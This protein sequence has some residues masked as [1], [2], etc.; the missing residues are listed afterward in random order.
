MTD[1]EN[2]PAVELEPFVER[3]GAGVAINPATGEALELEAATADRLFD[4]LAA[5]GDLQA[6]LGNHRRR[7][8][9]ELARR[10]DARNERTV[11]LDGCDYTVNAPTEDVI[12]VE[13]I[14]EQAAVFER[15]ADDAVVAGNQ[16]AAALYG[17]RAHLLRRLIVTPPP[18][19]PPARVDKRAYARLAKS[20]DRELLGALAAARRRV[21]TKRTVTLKARVLNTT[22]EE[23]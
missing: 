14:L 23:V 10:A 9:L 20:D 11:T 7:V 12:D 8:E 4:E 18:A 21:P 5:V 19:R 2:T 16:E 22:A 15:R 1:H 6:E 13:P 3:K 17:E